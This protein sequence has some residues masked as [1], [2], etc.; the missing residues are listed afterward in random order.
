[1]EDSKVKTILIS[2]FQMT[3]QLLND[4]YKREEFGIQK[5]EVGV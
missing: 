3:K 2:K 5:S 4:N 1:M